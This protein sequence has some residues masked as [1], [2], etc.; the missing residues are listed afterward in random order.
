MQTQD[1]HPHL[2][3]A[4][5]CW[6]AIGPI[7]GLVIGNYFQTK[8][9]HKQWRRDNVRQEC[10]ELL[11]QLSVNLFALIDW[12]RA[13]RFENNSGKTNAAT[14]AATENYDRAVVDL[15]RNLG[16]RLLIANEIKDAKIS[17]RWK[18]GLEDY[19]LDYNDEKLD[20]M[21]GSLVDDIVKIGLKA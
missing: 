9:Q 8:G 11:G 16:S 15:H 5:T 7:I 3:V 17:E 2:T 4:L 19:L 18:A 6:A 21:Y 14:N 1:A 12:T 10:R 20:A 13:L